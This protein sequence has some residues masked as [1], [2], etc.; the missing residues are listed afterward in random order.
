MMKT[1][2]AAAAAFALATAVVAD[3]PSAEASSAAQVAVTVTG[4]YCVAQ[5]SSALTYWIHPN[6]NVAQRQALAE[7]AVRTASNDTCYITGCQYGTWT[8]YQ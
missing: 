1:F 3:A 2:L 6:R 8:V 7:C 5:S 4:Y